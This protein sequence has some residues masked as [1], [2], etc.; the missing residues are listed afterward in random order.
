M[1]SRT[2]NVDYN[3]TSNTS[4]YFLSLFLDLKAKMNM[5]KY[6][7]LDEGFNEHVYDSYQNFLLKALT[8]LSRVM[9]HRFF[10]LY[11]ATQ[12]FNTTT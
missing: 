7:L 8:S 4:F 3:I 2:L 9:I 6:F 10:Y 5:L 12:P 11:T 1:D